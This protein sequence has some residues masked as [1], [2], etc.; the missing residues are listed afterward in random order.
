MGRWGVGVLQ[1][2]HSAPA[3]GAVAALGDLQWMVLVAVGYWR[4]VFLW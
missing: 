3:L 1:L 4:F 2:T